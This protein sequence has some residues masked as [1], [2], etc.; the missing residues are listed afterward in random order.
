MTAMRRPRARNNTPGGDLT[1]AEH[2]YLRDQPEPTEGVEYGEWWDLSD[3]SRRDER[4]FG[5]RVGRPTVRQLWQVHGPGIVREWAVEWPGC[6]PRLWWEFD[7][8]R[9]ARADWGERWGRWP[10]EAPPEP[11]KRLGGVGTPAY[12]VLAHVPRWWRGI[13]IDWVKASDFRIYNGGL[14]AY[15]QSLGPKYVP[16]YFPHP[17]PDPSDPP[18]FESEAEYLR[19]HRL[20]LSGEAARLTPEDLEPERLWAMADE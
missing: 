20:L 2:A 3:T 17:P 12:E 10:D 11:R 18:L 8:P 7:A 6:R 13:P 15:C 14:N 1:P 9:M 19:R 16:G 4:L 5:F